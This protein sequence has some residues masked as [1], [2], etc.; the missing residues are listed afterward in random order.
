M[1]QQE[2]S[3]PSTIHPINSAR[4][5]ENHNPNRQDIRHVTTQHS[6]RDRNP[7]SVP[8]KKNNFTTKQP[9]KKAL[10]SQRDM[11]RPTQG[12]NKLLNDYEY[13]KREHQVHQ[14][15]PIPNYL[16]NVQ[17]KE[18]SL[19][20]R[21]KM[22]KMNSN[23]YNKFSNQA[24]STHQFNNQRRSSKMDNVEI[25]VPERPMKRIQSAAQQERPRNIHRP[26]SANLRQPIAQTMKNMNPG[27]N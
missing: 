2:Q 24:T 3:H 9:S 23:N 6:H 14:G 16:K 26:T 19:I 5:N 11:G 12:R 4:F 7:I 17:S 8:T 1:I 10:H 15:K 13:L 18:R 25:Y 27:Y 22:A 21:D 20:Q